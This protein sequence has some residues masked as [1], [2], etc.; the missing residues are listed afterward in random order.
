MTT[1]LWMVI[2]FSLVMIWNIL[3]SNK[4]RKMKTKILDEAFQQDL[5]CSKAIVLLMVE[6][7]K[8]IVDAVSNDKKDLKAVLKALCV[9]LKIKIVEEDGKV[10]VKK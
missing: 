5:L 7:N 10:V 8:S 1:E 3:L 9:H 6:K 4:V 2:A